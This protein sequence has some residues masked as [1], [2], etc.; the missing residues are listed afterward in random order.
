M[1]TL[2]PDQKRTR[3]RELVA[4]LSEYKIYSKWSESRI[5]N[6]LFDLKTMGRDPT[7]CEQLYNKQ[8]IQML[9]LH[10]G[11]GIEPRKGQGLHFPNTERA[12]E[13]LTC[14][15]N[16][17]LTAESTRD[18]ALDLHI[19]QRLSYLVNLADCSPR[20]HFLIA[21]ILFLLTL[22]KPRVVRIAIDECNI[23]LFLSQL[24][25]IHL[26]RIESG[27]ASANLTSDPYTSVQ[28]IGELLKVC[29]NVASDYISLRT[30]TPD[31]PFRAALPFGSSSNT[32]RAS[33]LNEASS[34]SS[35]P[36]DTTTNYPLAENQL[37]VADSHTFGYPLRPT[38][39]V[40]LTLPMDRQALGIPPPHSNAISVLLC[41][42]PHAFSHAFFPLKS[43]LALITRLVEF[44]DHALSM[45]SINDDHPTDSTASDASSG[46]TPSLSLYYSSF[47]QNI[48]HSLLPLLWLLISISQAHIPSRLY[49][50]N[51]WFPEDRNRDVAPESLDTPGGRLVFILAQPM[52]TPL[53]QSV[54][55]LLYNLWNNDVNQLVA[56][57]GY[58][59]IAGYL[60]EQGIAFSESSF[61]ASQQGSSN[62][63][64]PRN[65]I[66]PI[67]GRLF[68][69]SDRHNG[70]GEVHLNQPPP[71]AR[72][73]KAGSAYHRSST[74]DG[75][76]PSTS[77]NKPLWDTPMSEE[78][79]EQE[80]EKL[81]VLFDRLNRTGMVKFE[82]PMA[83]AVR[84][85]KFEEVDSD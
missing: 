22:R 83:Q 5:E 56:E 14:L 61:Q 34:A 65:T 36:T 44:C 27:A 74:G 15:A 37:A 25:N 67:T 58:G 12:C 28:V 82:H 18:I 85:G 66:N 38:L 7:G 54:G 75:S 62:G 52:P 79:K 10:A 11:L 4:A 3:I 78:E 59:N 73:P 42:S 24:L 39:E 6:A 13:A 70:H 76:S 64:S 51:H 19:M 17:F 71:E 9:M 50:R 2:T 35:A 57:I 29:Y 26:R 1:Q 32:S 30:A 31:S 43:S 80:A 46:G 33:L 47:N 60:V 23:N 41:Y 69:G 63:S 21:R 45:L 48:A 68:S 55:N 84:Q 8:G 49:M 40:I 77:S 53:S 81:M 72:M 20:C 16:M